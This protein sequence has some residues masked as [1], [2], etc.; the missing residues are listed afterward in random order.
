RAEPDD[1]RPAGG[2]RA[3]RALRRLAARRG[4]EGVRLGRVRLQERRHRRD[5]PARRAPYA[6][7]DPDRRRRGA[8]R[9]RQGAVGLAGRD[10][11]G[12]AEVAGPERPGE[13]TTTCAHYRCPCWSPPRCWSR[14]AAT[15][16][17]R[18]RR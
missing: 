16:T 14:D 18:P 11:L 2:L 5:G 9:L 13:G 17:R 3:A 7:R 8:K 15:V 4:E 6:A 12:G 1:L 10:R